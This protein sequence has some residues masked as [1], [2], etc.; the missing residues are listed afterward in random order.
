MPL[1]KTKLLSVKFELEVCGRLSDLLAR[2]HSSLNAIFTN[3]ILREMWSPNSQEPP[4][5]IFV[6]KLY[7][8]SSKSCLSQ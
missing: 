4:F 8:E 5:Q 7:E 2:Y 1:V 6:T 3:Y